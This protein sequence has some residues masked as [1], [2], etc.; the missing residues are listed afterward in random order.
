M[1]PWNTTT[2]P[3]PHP[4][5]LHAPLR[6]TSLTSG[7][8][9]IAWSC[10]TDHWSL[11]WKHPVKHENA[12]FFIRQ[13]PFWPLW[14]SG[15]WEEWPGLD[16]VRGQTDQPRLNQSWPCSFNAAFCF[17]DRNPSFPA[18]F[19]AKFLISEFN[20][21]DCKW[22]RGPPTGRQHPCGVG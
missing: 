12:D 7:W 22:W 21:A 19:L 1:F 17:P 2:P 6:W 16:G 8:R 11:S 3:Q 15:T 4:L 5:S 20:G 9:L 18:G 14:P 13:W 10:Q